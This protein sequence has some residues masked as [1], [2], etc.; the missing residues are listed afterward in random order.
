LLLARAG[1][2]AHA[3]WLAALGMGLD[4]TV[5]AGLLPAAVRELA[6]TDGYTS[7]PLFAFSLGW[8]D[9]P[10]PKPPSDRSRKEVNHG[11]L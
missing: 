8:P 1:A 5:F 3:A 7:A 11:Q 10:I 4:G 6:G 2:A 9:H